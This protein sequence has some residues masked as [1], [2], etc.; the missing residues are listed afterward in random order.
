MT[1]AGSF[2]WFRGLRGFYAE[3]RPAAYERRV[4]DVEPAATYPLGADEFSLSIVI[5]EQ[6]YPPPK[7]TIE[8]KVTVVVGA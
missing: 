3:K 6:R 8:P 1:I 5:L 2:C 7:E 4:D